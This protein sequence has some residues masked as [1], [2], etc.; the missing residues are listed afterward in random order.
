MRLIDNGLSAYKASKLTGVPET[1]IK[2]RRLG[3]VQRDTFGGGHGPI[4]TDCQEKRLK[5]HVVEMMQMGY[6][7][8]RRELIN[9]ATDMAHYLKK[10]P[11]DKSLSEA[12]LYLGFLKR[13][14]NITFLKPRSLSMCRAKAV[15]KEN[16]DTYFSNLKSIMD[17]YNLH[18]KPELIYN[19]D[20][21]G[22]SPEHSPPRIATIKGHTPQAVTSPRSSMVTCIGACNGLA[23]A[24]PPY[25]IHKGK[26]LNDDLQV[27]CS[28]GCGFNISQSGW[29]N[30][31]ADICPHWVHL[32]FC[33]KKI[34][35]SQNEIFLCPCCDQGESEQ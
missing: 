14:S 4:F 8:T 5:E 11:E 34:S 15:T 29:S 22:F 27:G 9:L 33:H 10:L 21:T 2:D 16:I 3:K 20:E 18:E 24:I 1:T 13:H 30:S 17:K 32:K 7:Y 25:L 31:S 23:T 6:G 12:W 28:P 26:R 35:V 19:I